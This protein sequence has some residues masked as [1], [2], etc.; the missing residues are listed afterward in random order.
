[1]NTLVARDFLKYG[2]KIKKPQIGDLVILQRGSESWQGHVG[3]FAGHPDGWKGAVRILN[4]NSKSKVRYS[5]FYTEKV[6][7]YRS[8]L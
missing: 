8:L 4:G 7:G 6:I 2:N 1:M 3:F 5:N